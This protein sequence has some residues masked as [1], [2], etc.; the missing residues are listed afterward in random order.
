MLFSLIFVKFMGNFCK[1]FAVYKQVK[2]SSTFLYQ[3]AG[4]LVLLSTTV[5]F[6]YL[7]KVNLMAIV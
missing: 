6:W 3:I 4:S 5:N 7:S 1:G 2:A